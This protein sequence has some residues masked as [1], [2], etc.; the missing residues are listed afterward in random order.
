MSI[1]SNI[2]EAAAEPSSFKFSA[3]VEIQAAKGEGKLPTFEIVAYTGVPM[4]AGGFYTPVIVELSGVKT[5]NE[6]IP[7][8]LDHDSSR[9]VGQ[10]SAKVDT[11]AIRVNGS[12]M[13]EDADSQKV[14][15]L[16][17][18]GF[19][20][21]A[22]IG[23]SVTRREFL[24]AGKKAN[25]N[26]REVSGPMVIARESVLQEVSFVAIGA[27]Q[28]TSA[29]VAASL[30]T[31]KERDM[32]F[33]AWLQAKG[34]DAA[35]I[36]DPVR[37]TLKASYDAE[38][39]AAADK[40]AADAI[41]A[42]GGNGG[43]QKQSHADFEAIVAANKAEAAR[44]S[45][46]TR[47]AADGLRDFPLYST[48]IEIAARAALEDKNKTPKDFELDVLR[49]CRSTV[50]NPRRRVGSDGANALVLEAALCRSTGLRDIDKI[51]KDE[52]LTACDAHFRDGIGLQELIVLAANSNGE[53]IRA[54]SGNA[55][56]RD[57]L[58][59]AFREDAR[60]IR[61]SNGFSTISLP[62]ILANVQN[63]FL[64]EAFMA[65]E[66]TWRPISSIQPVNDF[67]AISRM[68][69][70][71]DL[72]Y[73]RVSATGEIP[74]GTVSERAYSN[75]A[76]TY[77]KM[78]AITREHII[79]DDLSAFAQVPRRLGR[80]GALCINDV[81]WTEFMDNASFFTTGNSNY[82][83]GT[84][85]ALDVAGLTKA[86][87]TFWY[88]Q[89]D[90][91]GKPLGSEPKYLLVP[92]TQWLPAMQLNNS[93]A[94]N[95]AGQTATTALVPNNNPF[96]GKFEVLKSAYLSSTSYTGYSTTAYYLL[97]DP[98]DIAVIEVCFL[99]GREMPV[100]ETADADFDQLGIKIRAYH[101]FGV[102]KQE[103][104]GGMK[105][106]GA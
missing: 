23:A 53:N 81:F 5:V 40:A 2:I 104:R 92:P 68:S 76:K 20:W 24:E 85:T 82:D 37:N 58:R 66:Q 86:V 27:D 50:A 30:S 80:G 72:Q 10:G 105:F 43:T 60:D 96:A 9:I 106:V 54:I 78:L 28:Q 75:Q 26:G 22:S 1:E 83:S 98:S 36:T 11:A 55:S 45:E 64:K 13:G 102:T 52:T 31:L 38:V 21:Q 32:N 56:L 71:G 34:I 17:K 87:G 100:V 74:H 18:N 49:A 16:A 42:A 25:V 12:V 62:N 84:D 94:L 47:I 73:E 19:K 51:Y 7:I 14:V 67:K 69:L 63:K 8:L 90:A 6:N 70:T 61:A 39:K 91:D 89:T 48:A 88:A 44:Q 59:C 99:G 93:T 4:N 46:I 79:N 77:G 97:C 101:D 33:E 29:A 65:V 95:P 57:A 103:F 15:A 3:P 35:N 41:K